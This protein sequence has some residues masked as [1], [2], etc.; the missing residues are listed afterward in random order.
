MYEHGDL[1]P[2]IS[3]SDEILGARRVMNNLSKVLL[4]LVIVLGGILAY[5]GYQFSN[6][7]FALGLGNDGFRHFIE[8]PQETKLNRITDNLYAFQWIHYTSMVVVTDEG[9]IVVDP[10]NRRAA[11]QLK[12]VLEEEFP[13]KPIAAVIYSHNHKDHTEGAEIL[14]AP[15]IIG[16]QDIAR[17]LA[18]FPGHDVQL[19][20]ETYTGDTIIEAAGTEIALVYLPDGHTRTM[21]AIHFPEYRAVY[22]A[23]LAT[24]DTMPFILMDM[25]LPAVER[26]LEQV[27]QIDF[28]YF[29]P[30]HFTSGTKEDVIKSLQFYKDIRQIARDALAKHGPLTET[31][32]F[33]IQSYMYDELKAQYGHLHGFDDLYIPFITRLFLSEL[34][35]Y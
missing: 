31:S 2:S 16:H 23:D 30:S 9:I 21:Y 29:V 12:V 15:R 35:G 25:Y 7:K 17:Y 26:N 1:Y 32:G 13:G 28:D 11:T 3:A 19:P 4:A 6:P 20:N 5:L 24:V 33:A 27:A 10:S 22:L 18:D 34:V 14:Q 8:Q